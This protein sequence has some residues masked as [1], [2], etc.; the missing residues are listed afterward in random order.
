MIFP[1]TEL[2]NE[3]REL[4]LVV[5]VL[6]GFAF[7]FTLE[8]AGFGR[9]TKLAGQFY[10]HD[11]TVFKVMFGAIVTAMLGL[12]IAA[13][14]GLADLRLISE[15]A[16]S[17]TYIWPM[18]LGGL[19]LGAGFIISG[20]CPGTSL[21][22]TASGNLDGLAAFGGVIVGS[23]IYSELYPLVESLH[24]S[25]AQGH[26]FL[27][28]LLGLPPSVLAGGV[29]VMALGC[30]L[31]AEKLERIF[32]ARRDGIEPVRAPR[33]FAFATVGVAAVLA[34]GTL[35][36]P[37][38]PATAEKKSAAG[39]QPAELARRVIERPW[40]IRVLDLRK[41]EKCA[42]QRVPGAECAPLA[43]LGELGLA[44][45]PPARDL[46]L[47]ASADNL[48]KVPRA[49]AGFK[50]DIY[51]LEGGFKAWKGYA[52]KKP[53]PP[54]A[55]ASERQ[56]AEHRVQSAVHRALTGA[57]AAV[58]PPRKATKF[59]PKKRRKTGGCG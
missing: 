12:A 31:G 46:V 52:L 13:G 15:T 44:Y 9:A 36:V 55:D 54:P 2:L 39:I 42:K 5:A 45:S 8:R 11:M 33:G 53:E 27:Y 40:K 22:A 43:T 51:I 7:G 29:A 57:R 32:S 48:K 59:V 16:A 38:A 58:P 14:L 34:V 3:H 23:L 20:Y 17:P 24:L 49:A 56:L 26:L 25:G 19:L 21:V 6:I 30:F 41:E 4:G 50:G 28:E 1:L 18:L 37:V 47:V 10:L 35:L